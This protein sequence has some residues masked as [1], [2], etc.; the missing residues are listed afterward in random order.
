MK[1]LQQ[2]LLCMSLKKFFSSIKVLHLTAE[3]LSSLTHFW[4]LKKLLWRE[5]DKMYLIQQSLDCL[6]SVIHVNQFFHIAVTHTAVS[7]NQ[8]FNFV[9]ASC[10]NNKVQS[11]FIHYLSRFLWVRELHQTFCNVLMTFIV[12]N[13]LLDVYFLK[14]HSM[15]SLHLLNLNAQYLI[16]ICSL[17]SEDCLQCSISAILSSDFYED[18]LWCEFHL[19]TEHFNSESAHHSFLWYDHVQ[20]VHYTDA[21]EQSEISWYW[22]NAVQKQ[23]NLLLLSLMNIQTLSFL[24]TH[25]LW[26]LCS[27]HQI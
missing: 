3:Q 14:M 9:L 10:Q 8:S 18:I 5:T 21:S 6:Y 1:D 11:D 24:W 13:I 27:K 7:I 23:S 4:W 12:L 17:W 26:H 20:K 19:V 16:K 25:H 22:L 15:I 2:S